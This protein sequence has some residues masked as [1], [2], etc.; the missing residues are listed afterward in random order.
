[1]DS[2]TAIVCPALKYGLEKSTI[3]SRS[4]VMVAALATTSNSP[5]CS[6]T[7]MPSQ[8]VLTNSMSKPASS[9]MAFIRSTSN[10]TMLPSSSTYSNGGYSA[11][12]PT[13]TTP[14]SLSMPIAVSSPSSV[15]S[16]VG[17]SADA[18]EP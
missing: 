14:S 9:A 18:P 5:D 15:A 1:R 16:S 4:S 2:S 6:A 17:S 7:K 10:P 3:S 8:R 12:M 13:V 11:F